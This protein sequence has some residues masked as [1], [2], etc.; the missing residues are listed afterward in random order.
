MTENDFNHVVIKD[1]NDKYALGR[2]NDIEVIIMKS[3][4]YI[5]G[6]KLCD[7]INEKNRNK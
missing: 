3:N 2:L 6:T 7:E 4:Y 5:N 1:I